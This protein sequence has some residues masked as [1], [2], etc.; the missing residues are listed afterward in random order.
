MAIFARKLATEHLDPAPLE[1]YISCRLI[2]LNKNP[3]VRPIGVGE[4]I[5]RIIGKTIAWSLREEVQE[6]AGPLQVASGIKGGAEAAIHAMSE[7]F[8]AEA[9]DAFNRLNRMVA[10]HNIQYI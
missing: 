2:P 9:T 3:G 10:L 6:V 5:R 8:H 7:I 1:P 4:V